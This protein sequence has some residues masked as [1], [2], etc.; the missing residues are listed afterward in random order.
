MFIA[1]VTM[2]VGCSE[3]D[4]K[5][6]LSQVQV[7]QSVVSLAAGEEADPEDKEFES[8][9]TINANGDWEFKDVPDWLTIT[10]VSGGAGKQTIVFKAKK[11]T[12]SRSAF[13]KLLCNG[14]EQ[15]VNVQQI[16][17][18]IDIPLSTCAEVVAGE[19]GKTY[20]VKGTV[21]SI[22]NT[23]YGNWY[24]VDETGEV[25][26]YGTL[27]KNGAEKNFL[28]LGIGVGD[29]VTVEGARKD[30]NG[31]IEMVN[32]TVIAIEKSLLAVDAIDIENN[33]IAK[34]GGEFHV[35]LSNKGDGL[36]VKI[37]EEAKDW[38]FVTGINISGETSTVTFKAL[39]NTGG[40]RKATVTFVT[41]SG[42][43]E[44]TAEA[45][46]TQEA[47]VLPHGENP[48]DPF[49]VAEA[50]AKCKAIGSTTDG[51]I[52]YAKGKISSIS[53]IDTGD[54]GNATFNISDN[55]TD[56]NALTCFRSKYLNN[57]KFTSEDQIG[58]GDE[59]VICGKLVDYK[60]ET[61]EFS[62]NVYIYKLKKYVPGAGDGS[63]NNPFSAEEA[64]AYVD[65]G[66]TDAV[67]VKGVVSELVKGGFGA[68]YG[69]GSFFI[70]D[71]GTKYG[72]PLKDFE[73]Y[74]VNYLGNRLWTE[75]DPQIA[76]GDVVIIYGPLTTYNTTRETK[77]KGA[78][79][80]YSLNGKTE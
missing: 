9:I 48:D 30:Y 41:T 78:A 47:D 5:S 53:S 32:V 69:N 64:I 28:S 37:P 43:K 29:I 79:Y 56:E 49:T 2:F 65:A 46:I 18:K 62:G 68:S 61:P 54:Y 21:K 14:Q 33:T 27:D 19:D 73:A 26:I 31:T 20:R 7:S 71:N 13:L 12:E 15:E 74:Q 75:A 25:Y 3:D 45:S 6:T 23:T 39:P 10:P 22:A 77:G 8:T 67:Y 40:A 80:I 52:Y 60:G 55:G 34:T 50:I 1:A 35:T 11:T 63:L 24:L 16:A 51:V 66:G 76:V 58:V 44:Y 4:E 70:S 42:G 38:L 72:D 36:D 17:K 57:E 59:V